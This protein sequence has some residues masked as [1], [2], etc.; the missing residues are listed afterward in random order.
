MASATPDLRLPSQSQDIT[1]RDWY[2][3]ILLGDRGHMCVNK[4]PKVVSWQRNGWELNSPPLES[5]AN[6]VTITPPGHIDKVCIL[7]NISV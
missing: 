7:P 4:L 3:I 1:A 2:Q 6:A 5:P